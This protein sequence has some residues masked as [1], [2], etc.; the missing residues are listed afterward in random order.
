MSLQINVAFILINTS[1]I[2][3]ELAKSLLS[4]FALF[5]TFKIHINRANCTYCHLCLY[6][7]SL[8]TSVHNAV[9]KN[10]SLGCT[11]ETHDITKFGI[12]SVKVHPQ[13]DDHGKSKFNEKSDARFLFEGREQT[14]DIDFYS[15]FIV[16][17]RVRS[18]MGR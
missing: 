9:N 6:D 3:Q 5:Y 4:F 7:V 14:T 16:T 17:A 2:W 10:P 1:R 11:Y 13:K 12:N 8:E 18:T 15:V